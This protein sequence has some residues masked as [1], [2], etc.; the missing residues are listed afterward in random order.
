[1]RKVIIYTNETGGVSVT[2]PTPEF[3]ETN[4]IEDVKQKDTPNHSIIVNESILPNEDNDFFD[5]WILNS[6]DTVSVDITKAKTIQLIKLNTAAVNEAKTRTANTAIGLINTP[7]D[8][9]WIVMLNSKRTAIS[10]ATTTAQL[11]TITLDS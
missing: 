11:R 10:N 8:S 5:A 6:D 2:Y 1:M 4:T 7:S 9:E 3:L